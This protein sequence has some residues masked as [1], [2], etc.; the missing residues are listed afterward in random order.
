MIPTPAKADECVDS[1]F[2]RAFLKERMPHNYNNEILSLDLDSLNIIP[3][4]IFSSDK[5]PDI[6]AY[7]HGDGC[8][9]GNTRGGGVGDGL[10]YGNGL[11]DSA[12]R[13]RG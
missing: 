11:G 13:W 6:F 7:E 4:I 2:T 1:F 5:F 10:G 3:S 8:G 9:Y 12:S